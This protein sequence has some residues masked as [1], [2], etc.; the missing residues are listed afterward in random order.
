MKTRKKSKLDVKHQHLPWWTA[1]TRRQGISPGDILPKS[2]KWSIRHQGA[3][4]GFFR[5]EDIWVQPPE[6]NGG[7]QA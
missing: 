4:Q 5:E 7:D 3:A 2:D 1:S 6:C